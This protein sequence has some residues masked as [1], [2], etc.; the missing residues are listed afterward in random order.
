MLCFCYSKLYHSIW[1]SLGPSI[2]CSLFLLLRVSVLFPLFP[3]LFHLRKS[4]AP[5]RPQSLGQLHNQP[6]TAAASVDLSLPFSPPS[7][8]PVCFCTWPSML[9]QQSLCMWSPP[10]LEGCMSSPHPHM[11]SSITGQISP[12]SWAHLSKHS[13]SILPPWP[14]VFFHCF[15]FP[16]SASSCGITVF[17]SL[18][19]DEELQESESCAVCCCIPRTRRGPSTR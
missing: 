13:S 8:P 5:S 16:Q 7:V 15:I 14:S 11:S 19:G 2:F 9:L 1:Q 6:H 4:Q 10:S 3:F 12:D 17:H 18:I